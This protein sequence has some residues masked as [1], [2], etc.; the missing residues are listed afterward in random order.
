[1]NNIQKGSVQE[2]NNKIE[3]TFELFLWI[4]KVKEKL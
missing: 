4:S 2:K 1:M 3:T